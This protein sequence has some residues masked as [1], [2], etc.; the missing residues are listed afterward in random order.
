MKRSHLAREIIE[1]IVLTVLIF[2][3]IRF[4]V[5]SY[6]VDGGSML[7]GLTTNEYVVVNKVAYMFNSPQRGD[8]IVFH[9]PQNTQQDYIKRVIGVPG[10]IIRTDAT[11]V[12]VNDTMLDEVYISSPSN[13]RGQTWIVPEGQFFVMGDNRPSSEDS[14]YWVGASFVPKEYIVGKAVL[15]FWPL[16]QI[17]FI[18]TYPDVYKDI[19]DPKDVPPP[20]EET[21]PTPENTDQKEPTPENTDQSEEKQE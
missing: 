3:V 4:V 14:R 6:H 2:L 8:V 17:H 21:E 18:N 12:W 15:V 19:K 1:T 20:T 7:P 16:N 5:Q 13:P 10:D 9:N 11:N